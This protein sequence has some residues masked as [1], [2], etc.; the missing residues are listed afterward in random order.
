MVGIQGACA[1][2]KKH[3]EGY[4]TIILLD[5]S[6][7]A[8]SELQRLR[9][10]K[11]RIGTMDLKI[12]AIALAQGATLLSRNLRDFKKVPGLDVEDWTS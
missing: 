5:F 10:M 3:L 6:V 12:A 7:E 4:R 11:I 2:L 1:K 9:Q 8:A